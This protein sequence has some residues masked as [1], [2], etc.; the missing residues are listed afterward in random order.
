MHL[1]PKWQ[2]QEDQFEMLE[3]AKSID[4]LWLDFHVAVKYFKIMIA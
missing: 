2:F 3:V 1:N 4:P